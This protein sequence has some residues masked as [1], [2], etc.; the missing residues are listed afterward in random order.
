MEQQTEGHRGR[1]GGTDGVQHGDRDGQH[2]QLDD[3]GRDGDGEG[4]DH[5]S[6]RRRL[7]R[8]QADDS[9]A[10]STTE[11]EWVKVPQVYEGRGI[12]A[13]GD[14][15]EDE[16]PFPFTRR[17]YGRHTIGAHHDDDEKNG[18]LAP[19]GHGGGSMGSRRD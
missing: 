4:G 15:H 16:Y 6:S 13:R 7:A 10:S 2:A 9:S 1:G 8:E 12:G 18:P 5:C 14:D 11:S 3:C 17:D 19:R